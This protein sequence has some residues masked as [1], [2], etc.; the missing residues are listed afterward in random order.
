MTTER[1]DLSRLSS[2]IN[3]ELNDWGLESPRPAHDR[4]DDAFFSAYQMRAHHL[5]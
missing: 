4:R 5:T 1:K 3:K 2:I